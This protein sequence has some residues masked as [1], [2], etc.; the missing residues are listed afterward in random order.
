MS[1]ARNALQRLFPD[2]DDATLDLLTASAVINEYPV[3][4][5]LTREGQVE[6]TFYLLMDGHADVYR[7]V[8]GH[9]F[10]LD[11]QE[12]GTAFGEIAL[13]LDTPRRADVVTREPVRVLEIKR[14]AFD[15]F[16]RRDATALLRV[17]QLILQRI[18]TQQDRRLTDLVNTQ[19]DAPDA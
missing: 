16:I 19:G 8:N 14:E 13:I 5:Y 6:D 18:L 15:R 4:T 1:E 10:V 17:V 11:Y 3:G 9:T 2:A 12:P 7:T